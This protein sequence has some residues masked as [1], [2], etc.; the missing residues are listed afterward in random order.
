MVPNVGYLG[1]LEGRWRVEAGSSLFWCY[2]V[3]FVGSTASGLAFGGRLVFGGSGLRVSIA[4]CRA[5]RGEG[6]ST[7]FKRKP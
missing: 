2:P 3:L 5:H 6:L 1:S 7:R 4:S